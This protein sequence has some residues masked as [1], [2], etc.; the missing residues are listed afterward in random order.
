MLS[1][2]TTF[3]DETASLDSD[4]SKPI[5]PTLKSSLKS[6]NRRTPS[7]GVQGAR[8]ASL[9]PGEVKDIFIIPRG[10]SHCHSNVLV[11]C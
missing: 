11:H 5:S 7:P 6:P 8:R 9:H 10:V 3:G 4:S 2:K 1:G